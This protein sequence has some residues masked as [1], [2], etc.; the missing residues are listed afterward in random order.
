MFAVTTEAVNMLKQNLLKTCSQAEFGFRLL[1]TAGD[2]E[3]ATVR[4]TMDFARAEDQV[5]N[6]DGVNILIGPASLN[7][8]SDLQ[9]D[10]DG[11]STGGFILIPRSKCSE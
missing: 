1:A 11:S 2:E 7:K 8:I 10:Y 4:I 3:E 6:A 9:L 5:I